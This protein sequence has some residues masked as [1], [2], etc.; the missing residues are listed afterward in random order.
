MINVRLLLVLSLTFMLSNCPIR[1]GLPGVE[2]V[3]P[4]NSPTPPPIKIQKFTISPDEVSAGSTVQ[5]T[6][7]LDKPAGDGGAE[8]GFSSITNTGLTDTIVNMPVSLRLNKGIK[9]GTIKVR[10]Q[11]VTNEATHI[12]F[13]AYNW[14]SQYS[15]ELLI[16]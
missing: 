14:N 15:A 9:E 3:S 6:V 2:P 8:I 7:T 12:V 4:S 11:R 1:P 16:H 10:T 13:T 5:F